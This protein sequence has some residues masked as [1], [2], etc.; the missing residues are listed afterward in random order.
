MYE[1]SD[2]V[3]RCFLGPLSLSV[4]EKQGPGKV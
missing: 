2:K 4:V 1:G 3:M